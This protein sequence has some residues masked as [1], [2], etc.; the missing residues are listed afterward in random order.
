MDQTALFDV[1]EALRAYQAQHGQPPKAAED[2]LNEMGMEMLAPIG[3]MAIRDD[4]VVVYW[5]VTLPDTNEV[6]TSDEG[7]D[8][9][10][11]YEKEVPDQGGYV[12]MVDRTVKQMTPEEFAAAAKPAGA[13]AS[14]G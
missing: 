8:T 3:V 10:L 9:V 5:G 14:A 4:E 2:V 13:S 12:L 7:A 1:G 6:A 11:A